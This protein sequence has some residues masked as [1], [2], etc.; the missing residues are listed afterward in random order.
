MKPMTAVACAMALAS[1]SISPALAETKCDYGSSD[2]FTFVKWE[3]VKLK[4][5]T[6]ELKLTY[7]NNL[8]RPLAWVE[9][10][11]LVD[12]ERGFPIIVSLN[13]REPIPASGDAVLTAQYEMPDDVVAKFHA[14]TPLLCVTAVD[15]DKGK[16]THYEAK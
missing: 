7:R 13:T 10:R 14:R 16:R 2:V 4:G 1:L 11:F 9:M 5:D 8:K 15:D 12:D 3:F 6:R